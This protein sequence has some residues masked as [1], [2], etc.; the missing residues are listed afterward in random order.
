MKNPEF[1][2][3][4]FAVVVMTRDVVNYESRMTESY[5]KAFEWAASIKRESPELDVF[6][7]RYE[8]DKLIDCERID[9]ISMNVR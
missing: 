8:N 1:N 2:Y 7:N 6:I 4:E 3:Y 5:K 9:Y